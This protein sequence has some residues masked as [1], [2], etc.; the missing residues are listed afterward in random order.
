MQFTTGES[1]NTQV[2]SGEWNRDKSRSE[3]TDYLQSLN[4]TDFDLG[5]RSGV[6]TKQVSEEVELTQRRKDNESV[7]VVETENMT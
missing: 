2:K 6:W 4:C 7:T 1:S 5:N 3:P